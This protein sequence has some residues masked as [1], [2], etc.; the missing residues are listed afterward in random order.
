M[1]LMISLRSARCCIIC[2]PRRYSRPLRGPFRVG[3]DLIGSGV[4]WLRFYLLGP[5]LHRTRHLFI[6]QQTSINAIRAHCAE[7]GPK[8]NT[9]RQG[10]RAQLTMINPAGDD[11]V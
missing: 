5:I 6:R 2:P 10:L 11:Q 3:L 7:F 8:A 1:H 9:N 4:V